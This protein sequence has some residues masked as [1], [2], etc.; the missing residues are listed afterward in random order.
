MATTSWPTLSASESPSGGRRQVGRLDLD[1]GEVGQ[2]VDAVDGAGQDAA[3]LELD[4]ELVAALDDVAVGQDP[5]VAVVD[6]A[7]ADAGL[8]DDAEVARVGRPVT[9]IRTTAGLTLAATSMVA[10]DSSIVTGLTAPTFVPGP[11]TE[12]GSGPVE[13]AGDAEREDGAA[14]GEDRRQQRCRDDASP[15][16]RR[17]ART[18]PRLTGPGAGAGSYQR[19][20][21]EVGAGVSYVRI[22][23]GRGSG[24]GE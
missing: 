5:A 19:S 4:V 22:H 8:G 23:S 24:V 16:R 3:V 10:D 9:V 11:T 20:G 13:R 2:G 21:V 15:C 14:G 7:R 6:D 17:L 18:R 12:A 1:D